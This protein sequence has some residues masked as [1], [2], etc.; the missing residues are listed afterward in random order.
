[1]QFRGVD[2]D[3]KLIPKV[4]IKFRGWLCRNVVGFIFVL[5]RQE[6]FKRNITNLIASLGLLRNGLLDC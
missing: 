1:M 6:I 2:I 3:L 5:D 4:A